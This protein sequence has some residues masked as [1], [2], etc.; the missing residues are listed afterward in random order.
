MQLLVLYIFSFYGVKSLC[1][2]IQTWKPPKF[3]SFFNLFYF[4]IN[5]NSSF[6]MWTSVLMFNHYILTHYCILLYFAV[7]FHWGETQ[8]SFSIWINLPLVVT[9]LRFFFIYIYSHLYY[10]TL[11]MQN[12]YINISPWAANILFGLLQKFKKFLLRKVFFLTNLCFFKGIS[13]SNIDFC[14][15]VIIMKIYINLSS[16]T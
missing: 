4:I 11:C 6:D 5:I 2:A 1:A 10:V 14:Y 13:L 8:H 16:D 7:W 3:K 9:Y 12:V 15:S